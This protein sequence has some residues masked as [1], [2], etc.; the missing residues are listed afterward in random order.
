CPTPRRTTAPA[1]ATHLPIGRGSQAN[2]FLAAWSAPQAHR[3][4]AP[5]PKGG[6]RVQQ[7][8]RRDASQRWSPAPG[9]GRRQQP[10]ASVEAAD[11][12]RLGALGPGGDVEGD[13][14]VL[15]ETAVAVSLDGAEV[16]K[17]VRTTLLGDEAVS[18]VG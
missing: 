2:R 5:H 16:H 11:V 7:L 17:K 10:S 13:L 3:F 18:L 15:S 12:R 9:R 14:L 6:Q 1:C 4:R 8:R